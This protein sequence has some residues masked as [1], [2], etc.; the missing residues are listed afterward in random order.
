MRRQNFFKFD[1][2]KNKAQIFAE[3][4]SALYGLDIA[5]WDKFI[6]EDSHPFDEFY[7]ENIIIFD[8]TDNVKARRAIENTS[9]KCS[10]R[11]IISCGNEDT[12]GQVL[13]SSTR[14]GGGVTNAQSYIETLLSLRNMIER[15]DIKN[16]FQVKY[17]P[18][19]LDLYRNFTDTEKPSC[20][21]IQLVDD[22]SMPINSI[23]AQIAYNMF[24]VLVSGGAFKY[25]MVKCS[26][27]NIFTTNIIT[28]PLA[29]YDLI[30]RGLYG[31]VTPELRAGSSAMLKL[32]LSSNNMRG[33]KFA[34]FT[35]AVRD[36]GKAVIPFAKIYL[37][38]AWYLTPAQ[39]AEITTWIH[40]EE[41][42]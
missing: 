18:T 11:T 30:L 41:G 32:Y 27:N 13:L 24:Y 22:Q 17:L 14:G 42:N 6:T 12:F 25:N 20:T 23:V 5:Y 34:Q 35:A 10:Y 37:I 19:L 33:M 38:G 1:V 16:K 2:G 7:G 21:E 9:T 31:D 39:L 15:P 8:C 40:N 3:R 36:Y 4:Y 26:I 29:A 28:N